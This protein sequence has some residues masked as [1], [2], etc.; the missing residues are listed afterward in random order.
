MAEEN[1][2]PGGVTHGKPVDLP[3]NPMKAFPG[4]DPA[5]V[6]VLIVGGLGH[7]LTLSAGVDNGDGTAT[8][9][10][11]DIKAGGGVRMR[12]PSGASGPHSFAITAISNDGHVKTGSLTLEPGL[13]TVERGLLFEIDQ[14]IVMDRGNRLGFPICIGFSSSLSRMVGDLE[15]TISGIPEGVHL[16]GGVSR[17]GGRW[18]LTDRDLAGLN[19]VVPDNQGPFQAI[20]SVEARGQSGG[21]LEVVRTALVGLAGHSV[22]ASELAKPAPSPPAGAP[23]PPSE[24]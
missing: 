2:N 21:Y 16:T 14:P 13:A 4:L 11:Q 9:L 24:K 6:S 20:L 5:D 8:L 12:F 23:A 7:R 19:F 1:G 10:D 22:L 18:S 3:L 17:G 15:M